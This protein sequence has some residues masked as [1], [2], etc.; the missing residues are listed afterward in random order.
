M[1]AGYGGPRTIRRR[2]TT[3]QAMAYLDA[4]QRRLHTA[5]AFAWALTQATVAAVGGSLKDYPDYA[6]S[7]EEYDPEWIERQLSR[8]PLMRRM[9]NRQPAGVLD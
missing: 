9:D 2:L 6:G 5:N 1:S 7:E 4:V 8:H 3:R